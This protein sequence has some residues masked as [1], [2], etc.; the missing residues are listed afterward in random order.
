[1][2]K[3]KVEKGKTL[4]VDGPASVNYISGEVNILGAK[5]GKGEKVV[6]REGKRVPFMVMKKATFDLALGEDAAFEEVEGST[7]PRSWE[8]ALKRYKSLWKAVEC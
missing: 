7:I 5:L 6:I 3:R 8:E 4:L 1:M 2:M